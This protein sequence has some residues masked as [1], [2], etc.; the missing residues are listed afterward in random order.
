[1]LYE[2]HTLPDS[3]L[4]DETYLVI[5][6]SESLDSLTRMLNGAAKCGEIFV[7]FKSNVTVNINNIIYFGRA[8]GQK[9]E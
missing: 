6:Y 3:S 7:R 1:M 5:E 2:I 4:K 9:N 8:A